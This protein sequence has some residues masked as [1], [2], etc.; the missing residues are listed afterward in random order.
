MLIVACLLMFEVSRVLLGRCLVWV[1]CLFVGCGLL[2]D[3]CNALFVVRC[4]VIVVWC[5]LFVC[6]M[7]RVASCSLVAVCCSMCV[8]C[9]FAVCGS[10][11]VG[12][13]LLMGVFVGGR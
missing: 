13:Y 10:L 3:V 5:L 7:L 11:L 2:C 6:C 12:C 8:V 1:V 4:L 9:C